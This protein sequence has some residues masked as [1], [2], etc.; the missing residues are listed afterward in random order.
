M[1]SPH[2]LISFLVLYCRLQDWSQREAFLQLDYR[3]K[4]GLPLIDPELI[5]V[6]KLNL[7][8]DEELGDFNIVI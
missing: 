5:P 2:T 1:E 8:S 4:N 7:P 3:E 6:E